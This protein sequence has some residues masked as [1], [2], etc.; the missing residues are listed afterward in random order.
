[1]LKEAQLFFKRNKKEYEWQEVEELQERI[2][3]NVWYKYCEEI[4]KNLLFKNTHEVRVG[5]ERGILQVWADCYKEL[6]IP[7]G[8]GNVPEEKVYFGLYQDIRT[9]SIPKGPAMKESLR[10]IGH[11]MKTH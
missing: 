11:Q 10:I 3:S 9:S 6:L 8:E 2:K 5:Y 7:L 4:H 1:M